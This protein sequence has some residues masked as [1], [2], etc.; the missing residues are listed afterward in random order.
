MEY[1]ISYNIISDIPILNDYIILNNLVIAKYTKNLRINVEDKIQKIEY[2][3]IPIN[4]YLKSKPILYDE[5]SMTDVIRYDNEYKEWEKNCQ[6]F[7]KNNLTIIVNNNF[8][9]YISKY[10]NVI[11]NDDNIL[12]LCNI[13]NNTNIL[14][15]NCGVIKH[16]ICNI[17]KNLLKNNNNKY[18][19]EIN[20]II[21]LIDDYQTIILNNNIN[22]IS[23]ET[24]NEIDILYN[25]VYELIR[26]SYK[27]LD[28][29]FI[30]NIFNKL[31]SKK[32]L[33]Y[34]NSK[35]AY[36]NSNKYVN[37][38]GIISINFDIPDYYW[39]DNIRDA[40]EM[41]IFEKEKR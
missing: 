15:N 20:D 24:K 12:I 38:E 37:N 5:Q 33:I 6:N 10:L 31:G 23:Q 41:Y 36:I 1:L 34:F 27:I 18:K 22:S 28:I 25:Q 30:L 13:C 39:K 19:E 9:D 29:N 32:S 14:K 11:I 26:E 2:C 4:P 7:E 8:N 21:K 3:I 35:Y 40:L 16:N 17:K